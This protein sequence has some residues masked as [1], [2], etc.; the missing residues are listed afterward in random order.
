[1]IVRPTLDGLIDGRPQS[2]HIGLG[3]LDVSDSKLS[4]SVLFLQRIEFNLESVD[5]AK[6]RSHKRLKRRRIAIN[7]SRACKKL[8]G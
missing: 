8:A 3:S 7:E 6:D 4:G 2:R 1:M 5:P